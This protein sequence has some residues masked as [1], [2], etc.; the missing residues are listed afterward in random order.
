LNQYSSSV[1]LEGPR[2]GQLKQPQGIAM[3]SRW[4]LGVGYPKP[5]HSGLRPRRHSASRD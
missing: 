1:V 5:P 4:R 3:D 2:P